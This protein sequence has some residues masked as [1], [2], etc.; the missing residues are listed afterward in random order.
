MKLFINLI[1]VFLFSANT[2][3]EGIPPGIGVAVGYDDHKLNDQS[4]TG[5]MVHLKFAYALETYPIV[6]FTLDAKYSQLNLETNTGDEEGSGFTVGPSIGFMVPMD[7]FIDNP[8]GP[9]G[10]GIPFYIGYN[11]IDTLDFDNAQDK[12]EG[13]SWRAGLQLPIPVF[14]PDSTIHLGL[15]VEYSKSDY[16]S[17]P[18]PGL[19]SSG[20]IERDGMSYMLNLAI[21]L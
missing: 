10:A 2:F 11:F 18:V 19:I 16:D 9:K 6:F 15:Q 8:P 4:L 1:M 3:A 21:F 5:P 7:L 17:K 14:P 12:L 20:D 13:T